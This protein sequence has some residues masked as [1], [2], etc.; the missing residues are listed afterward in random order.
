MRVTRVRVYDV[1]ALRPTNFLLLRKQCCAVVMGNDIDNSIRYRYCDTFVTTVVRYITKSNLI[2]LL[3][4]I[5]FLD[6][7]F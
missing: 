2:I 7:E 3:E 4:Y 6:S 5:L 1:F